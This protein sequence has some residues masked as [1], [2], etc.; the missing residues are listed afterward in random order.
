MNFKASLDPSNIFPLLILNLSLSRP[1]TF[2][3]MGS[4]FTSRKNLY[5]ENGDKQGTLEEAIK[6]QREGCSIMHYD[7]LDS[8]K[9]K[10]LAP[11]WDQWY[12]DSL[13]RAS[14]TMASLSLITYQTFGLHLP[15]ATI[16]FPKRSILGIFFEKEVKQQD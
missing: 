7:V 4:L 6:N 2:F 11:L 5:W 16:S 8:T 13:D 12:F 14:S 15:V 9:D 1:T 10:Y 3:E